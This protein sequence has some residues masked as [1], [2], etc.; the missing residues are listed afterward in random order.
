MKTISFKIEHAKS[1]GGVE[2]VIKLVAQIGGF[3]MSSL[4]TLQVWTPE[5]AISLY[6]FYETSDPTQGGHTHIHIHRL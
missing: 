6:F 2:K 5:A 4:T 1:A 3:L